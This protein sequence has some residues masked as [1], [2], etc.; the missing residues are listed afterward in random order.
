MV[1]SGHNIYISW[2]NHI[3]K[4]T[5]WLLQDIG[6]LIGPSESS[7]SLPGIKGPQTGGLHQRCLGAQPSVKYLKGK[8]D[9]C[10]KIYLERLLKPQ[11]G[12][13]TV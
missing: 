7:N 2:F 1:C 6:S 4:K 11:Y 8:G 9:C 13:Y 12:E 5:T 10:L 3:I